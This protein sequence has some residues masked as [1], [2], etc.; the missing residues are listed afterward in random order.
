[1]RIPDRITIIDTETTGLD[2]R[3]H[4]PWEVAI[5]TGEQAPN[6]YQL[7]HDVDVA[8]PDALKMNGYRER[9]KEF[10]HARPFDLA[11]LRYQLS[12][13]TVAGFNVR[14]DLDMLT[15]VFRGRTPWHYRTIEVGSLAMLMLGRDEPVG[16]GD[17]VRSL[18]DLYDAGIPDNDHSAEG[19]VVAT[20]EV[21]RFILGW[22]AMLGERP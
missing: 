10:M 17:A 7:D 14:F 12:G 6:V 15:P 8:D 4:Q 21:L 16:L 1:M 22:R 19:D 2:L 3:I 9:H 13:Q 20:R 11:Y 18:N 5:A